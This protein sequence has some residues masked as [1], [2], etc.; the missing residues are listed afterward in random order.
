MRKILKAAAVLALVAGMVYGQGIADVSRSRAVSRFTTTA[1]NS[2]ATVTISNTVQL[3]AVHYASEAAGTAT[4]NVAYVTSAGV[5]NALP[6]ISISA[7]KDNLTGY[8]N[9]PVWLLQDDTLRLQATGP[10]NYE[11]TYTLGK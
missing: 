3:L 2:T 10:L 4:G 1:S 6:A 11:I 5:T 9:T 8:V 7:A